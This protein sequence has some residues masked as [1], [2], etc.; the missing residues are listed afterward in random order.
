MSASIVTRQPRWYWIPVR[1]LLVTFIL[2]LLSFAVCLLLGILGVVVASHLRGVSPDLRIAYR[3]VALP[4]ATLVCG[5][6]FVSFSTMEVR[7]F[8]QSRALAGIE[9]ASRHA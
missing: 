7:H 8:R 9:R 3:L 5:V 6:V 2:T 1:I 4:A